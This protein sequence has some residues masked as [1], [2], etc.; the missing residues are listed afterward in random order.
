MGARL[1]R[2]GRFVAWLWLWTALVAAL[3]AVLL[4][5]PTIEDMARYPVD[6]LEHRTIVVAHNFDR[7][8]D[9]GGGEFYLDRSGLL[10]KDAENGVTIWQANGPGRTQT[11][12][13]RLDEPGGQGISWRWAGVR[14]S[15]D[16]AD[17]EVNGERFRALAEYLRQSNQPLLL[18]GGRAYLAGA[19]HLRRP[20]VMIPAGGIMVRADEEDVWQFQ[21][22]VQDNRAAWID[23]SAKNLK[24]PIRNARSRPEWFGATG[25]GVKGEHNAPHINAAF[26]IARVVEIAG[27]YNIGSEP[28]RF[29]QDG[30]LTGQVAEPGRDWGRPGASILRRTVDGVG[31]L[32]E[33]GPTLAQQLR[34][35]HLD[36]LSIYGGDSSFSTNL[37]EARRVAYL[38]FDE[39]VTITGPFPHMREGGY[40]LFYGEQVFDS[41]FFSRFMGGGNGKDIP[42]IEIRPGPKYSSNQLFFGARVMEGFRGTAVKIVGPANHITFDGRKLETNYH[43]IRGDAPPALIFE[44]CNMVNFDYVNIFYAG[45]EMNVPAVVEFKD[46][47]NVFGRLIIGASRYTTQT[48][49]H[50]IQGGELDAGQEYKV[51]KASAAFDAANLGAEEDTDGRLK[52][53]QSGSPEA[54]GDTVLRPLLPPSNKVRFDHLIRFSGSHMKSGIDLE[55]VIYDGSTE[56]IS[57]FRDHVA[58]QIDEPYNAERIDVRVTPPR[59]V[60]NGRVRATNLEPPLD[61]PAQ[62]K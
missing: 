11:Y 30:R 26:Q 55:V 43:T 2:S 39:S 29:P 5:F 54:W 48:Y 60:P 51:Q 23:T 38:M 53:A 52:V 35:L 17:A 58:V 47:W 10:G 44:N 13:R 33:G 41:Q 16:P 18:D 25:Y 46:C 31:L 34:S 22:W 27:H 3:P 4:K 59:H 24:G 49:P 45:D 7:Q 9:G 57:N 42:T 6:G 15:D 8:G 36:N 20:L 1:T 14:T 61:Q 32:M 28:I 37:I 12:W 56:V 62:N 50:Q 40:R 21:H 19:I